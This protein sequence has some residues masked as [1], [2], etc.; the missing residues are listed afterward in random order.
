MPKPPKNW[1]IGALPRRATYDVA[2]YYAGVSQTTYR[3]GVRQGIYPAPDRHGRIDLREVDA[4]IDRLSTP[5]EA[6]TPQ[7]QWAVVR[8]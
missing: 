7:S 1:P 8:R 3:E 5:L 6:E 2:A 4:A